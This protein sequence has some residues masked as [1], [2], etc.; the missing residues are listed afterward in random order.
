MALEDQ[1]AV[2]VKISRFVG[3]LIG[4]QRLVPTADYVVAHRPLLGRVV[5]RC[6]AG[7]FENLPVTAAA[8]GFSVK[9]RGSSGRRS[10]RPAQ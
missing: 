6:H 1:L 10:S 2:K 9:P 4:S 7:F 5:A 8:V 3:W